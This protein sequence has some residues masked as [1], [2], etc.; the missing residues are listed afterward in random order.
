MTGPDTPV[1]D[2]SPCGVFPWRP[3]AALVE[4]L[5]DVLDGRVLA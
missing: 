1:L 2:R 3:P 5:S 4:T